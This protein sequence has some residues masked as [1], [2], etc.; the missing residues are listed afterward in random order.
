MRWCHVHH[1]N[2]YEC[3]CRYMQWCHVTIRT[4]MYACV[5]TC[6]GA[7]FTIRTCMYTC[8]G[9]CD[10]AMFTIRICTCMYS[11]VYQIS[12]PSLCLTFSY[13]DLLARTRKSKT[14]RQRN[15][16]YELRQTFIIKEVEE[17]FA[18]CNVILPNADQ[19]DR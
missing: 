7:M 15:M 9:A 13:R 18:I 5:G 19:L 8:V 4:C 6:N 12:L 3:M 1:Q 17:V 14:L 2:M 16:I 10:G 11:Q